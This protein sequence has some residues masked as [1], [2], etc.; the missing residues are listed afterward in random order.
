MTKQILVAYA[1]GAGTTADVAAAIAEEIGKEGTP[2]DVSNVVDVED[3]SEYSAVV[4]G[5]SIRLGRWLPEAIEF[6]EDFQDTLALKPVALFTTCLTM[7]TDSADSR[8]TVLAYMEPLLHLAPGMLPVGIGLF[9]GALAPEMRLIIPGNHGPHGDFRN[10]P[11]IRAWAAS[12]RPRLLAAEVRTHADYDLHEAVL[13]Y[14]DLSSADLHNIDLQQADLEEADLSR[15]DLSDATLDQ[16]N[17]ANAD[18][19]RANLRDS[20]L[21]WSNL[22]GSDLRGA[23]LVGANLM[24]ADLTEADLSGADLHNAVLNGAILRHAKLR[25]CNLADSDLIWA[26]LSSADL[27]EAKLAGARLGWANLA[28]AKLADAD[29]AGAHYNAYTRWPTDFSPDEAG[30]IRSGD[31]V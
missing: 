4:V 18:L 7:V 8:Q 12:I 1:T 27:R 26:D 28:D 5:S 3:L 21:F 2:V 24:G 15:S 29:L 17:L 25:A 22:H 13:S 10:W 11:A 9:A 20:H 6:I 31:I 30:C 19:R 16:A 23:V 14:T